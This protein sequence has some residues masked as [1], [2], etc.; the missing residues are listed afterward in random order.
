MTALDCEFL[1]ENR[2]EGRLLGK[3]R[4]PGTPVQLAHQL[5]SLGVPGAPQGR[6]W[7]LAGQGIHSP[8]EATAD[9]TGPEPDGIDVFSARPPSFELLHGSNQQ[10]RTA[11]GRVLVV[12]LRRGVRPALVW[13]ATDSLSTAALR[14][15]PSRPCCRR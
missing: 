9:A 8:E 4:R 11:L 7:L 13:R 15:P 12:H 10:L 5:Q 3:P 14:Q 2:T 6:R 1:E